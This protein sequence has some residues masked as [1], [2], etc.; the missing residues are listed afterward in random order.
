MRSS[1]VNIDASFLA[2]SADIRSLKKC[3]QEAAFDLSLVF[4]ARGSWVCVPARKHIECGSLPLALSRWQVGF[5]RRVI[6]SDTGSCSWPSDTYFDVII[7]VARQSGQK[8]LLQMLEAV[9]FN[10][11][12][13]LGPAVRAYVDRL[14][15]VSGC[16]HTWRRFVDYKFLHSLIEL[17]NLMQSISA[18]F[19]FTKQKLTLQMGAHL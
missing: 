12:W 17:L 15:S 18:F 9:G 1:Y 16:W 4:F 2:A 5:S 14:P 10:Y 3:S 13:F 6:A 7:F 19:F 8:K 11:V